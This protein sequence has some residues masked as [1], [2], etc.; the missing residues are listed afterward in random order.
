M[1]VKAA[2][3]RS[4]DLAEGDPVIVVPVASATLACVVPN[5]DIEA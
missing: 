3:C 1:A 2:E 5:R 4:K